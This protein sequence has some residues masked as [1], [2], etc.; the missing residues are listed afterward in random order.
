MDWQRHAFHLP[1]DEAYRLRYLLTDLQRAVRHMTNTLAE[2]RGRPFYLAAR[3]AGSL[4]MCHRI[5]YDIATWIDEDL[6]DILIPS[7]GAATDPSIEVNSFV[8]MCC[9]QGIDVYPGLDSGLP[10]LF[11]GPEDQETKRN[12]RT[13]AITSRYYKAGAK[14]I[15]V[16][17]W[18]ANRDSRRELLS[19]IG[20]MK[21]LRNTNKIYAATHR[22]IQ[23]EGAWR[24]AYR[25]DR[26]Y[27]EV[28]VPL[29]KPLTDTGPIITLDIADEPVL[30]YSTELGLRL[31]LS[32]WVQGDIVD[33][34]WD[35]VKLQ[36]AEV[37]YCNL[38]QSHKI[39]D[40]S[41]AV[42]LCFVMQPTEIEVGKHK[43][44]VVLGERHPQLAGD[45]TLTDVELV[46]RKK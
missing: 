16:F 4:E 29:K 34:W 30:D 5:G 18:H 2:E 39:S 12:M 33:V 15:Y 46:I 21:T 32:E 10:D 45:I 44:K 24:G 36:N 25:I 28:P 19:Q 27:G 40:V 38:S 6:V 22:F 20:S 13:C 8:N 7:G 3:V 1:E 17:N 14:G 35:G 11:V 31:R 43:V 37:R 23:R 41:S 9:D 42:W 26:I